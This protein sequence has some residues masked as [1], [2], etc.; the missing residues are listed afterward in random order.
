MARMGCVESLFFYYL[1]FLP[2]HPLTFTPTTVIN[3]SIAEDV[4]GGKHVFY[5]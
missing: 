2:T 4:Y 1:V 3:F 5:I